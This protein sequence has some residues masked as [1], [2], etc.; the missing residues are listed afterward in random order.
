MPTYPAIALIEYSSIATG[1]LAG[2]AMVKQAPITVLK[3]GTVHNGKY[4][5]LIGGSTAAVEEA[6]ARGLSVGEDLVLDKMILPDVHRQVHDAILGQRRPRL[7]SA[8]GVIETATVAATIKSADAGVKG[9]EVEL[10]EI[11]LADDLGGKAFAI[12]SGTVEAVEAAV[13]IARRAVTDTR[14]WVRD[15][16][17]PRLHEAMG[18]IIDHSTRFAKTSPLPVE[19]SEL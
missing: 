17:I 2:D 3:A 18:E 11:R 5:V 16:I 10:V 19:G 13:D 12:F 6:Y 14:F 4:L 7:E 8:L 1:V 9:A 15:T